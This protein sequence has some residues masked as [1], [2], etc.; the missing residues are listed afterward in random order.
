MRDLVGSL[1]LPY[2]RLIATC[3]PA[4]LAHTVGA[5]EPVV[6][7]RAAMVSHFGVSVKLHH[8][9]VSLH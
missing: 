4:S 3:G 2:D 9:S 8:V 6:C 5:F 7:Y 1:T